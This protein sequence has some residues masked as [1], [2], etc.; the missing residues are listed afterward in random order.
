ME[1]KDWKYLIKMLLGGFVFV[2]VGYWVTEPK[3]LDSHYELPPSDPNRRALYNCLYTGEW[4][5][6][7]DRISA[8]ESEGLNQKRKQTQSSKVDITDKVEQ[9]LEEN[10]VG[11]RKENYW[12]SSSKRIEITITQS[13]DI[14]IDN[15]EDF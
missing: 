3:K 5:Y 4:V 8:R 7:G 11:Y 2:V 1:E 13:G 9:Y 14:E 10:I 6:E 12:S 15:M